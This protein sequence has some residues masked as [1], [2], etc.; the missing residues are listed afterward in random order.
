[1]AATQHRIQIITEYLTKN[2][3][4]FVDAGKRAN[5][6]FIMSNKQFA[7]NDTLIKTANSRAIKYAG[8]I[9]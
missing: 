9:R 7:R 8:T 6:V 5:H 3:K 2:A 1:M 4:G